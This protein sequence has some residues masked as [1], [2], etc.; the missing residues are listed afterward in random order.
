MRRAFKYRLFPNV[1]Q[2]RELASA[3]ETHR[4]LY[5]DCLA[6]RKVAYET[7]KRS[8]KYGEQSAW[9]KLERATN[10]YFARLNF[11]SA[12][13][14]MRRLEQ[15]YA[16]FFRR[17]KEGTNQA[18]YPRFKGR[19]RYDSIIYP[20]H[21]DGIRLIGNRLRV[22]HAG[23]I[24]VKLHRPV[25]GAIKTLTIKRE[26]EK[27]F[28]I[29]SCELPDVPVVA[30]TNPPVGVDVGL[31][32]FLTTSNGHRES[33]PRYHKVA[34]PKLR[35]AGRAVARKKKGGK[36]RRKAVHRLQKIHARVR[37]LRREHHYQVAC[38]LVLAFGFIA[39]EAL[40]IKGMLANGRLARAISD[41]GWAGFLSVLRGKAEKAGVQFVEVDPRGTSQECSQCDQEVRKDLSV[42]WH[43]C[44]GCGLSL[45]RDHNAAL[46]ILA[47]GLARTGPAKVNVDQQV[48][49]PP[50]SRRVYATE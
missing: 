14:T 1:N 21:G 38:R 31:T 49:R 37:N 41:A 13:A 10:P 9:F 20:S 34:L 22:Q 17:C 16:N 23:T 36:N 8:V 35:V 26:S 27:W 15:S 48:K 42:R 11:S 29:V 43:N 44:P 46:N 32:H 47:R 24:R 18:G 39:V 45:D 25:Q 4:R 7:E 50:R 2:A 12:Q 28:V 33:N 6:Q 5:N 40:N 3:L 30:A 19:D